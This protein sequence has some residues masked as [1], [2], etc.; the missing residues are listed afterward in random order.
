MKKYL[1][2]CFLFVFSISCN[3][4]SKLAENLLKK[5]RAFYESNKYANAKLYLD[6]L[7]VTF[8]KEAAIQKERLQLMHQVELGEQERNLNYCDSML[9]V[10]KIKADSLKKNFLFEKDENYDETGKY[11]TKQQKIENNLQKTYIRCNTNEQGEMYL[12]SVYYGTKPINHTKIKVSSPTGGYTETES[13]PKDGGLNYSFQDLGATTEIVTYKKGKDGGVIQFICNNH[14]E[15]LKAEYI[16]DKS[17]T[18]WLTPVEK[19][20]VVEVNELAT[21]LSDIDRLK[22]EI[23]KAKILI[24]YLKKKTGNG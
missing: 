11:L 8:P 15:K 12:E 22:N 19:N 1:Y 18:V 24:E 3:N 17:Y 14:N 9:V 2:L 21:V 13:I 7:K 20:A 23:Q 4:D 10:Y 5:A 6:S 16:G